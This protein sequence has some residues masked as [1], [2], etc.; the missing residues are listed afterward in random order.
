MGIPKDPTSAIP[1][2]VE[3]HG[4]VSRSIRG[5]DTDEDVEAHRLTF[6]RGSDE[7]QATESTDTG[8]DVEAHRRHFFK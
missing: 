6:G 1:E 2:D 5:R 4:R 3:G 8:E 7:S